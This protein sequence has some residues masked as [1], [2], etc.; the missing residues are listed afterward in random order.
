MDVDGMQIFYLRF[1]FNV[2]IFYF[3]ICNFECWTCTINRIVILSMQDFGAY[4]Q[5]F[6]HTAW[7]NIHVLKKYFGNKNNRIR[8]RIN[9]IN[10]MS[11]DSYIV[12]R[13]PGYSY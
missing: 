9:L 3:Q 7:K 8:I 4:N 13:T 12:K 11:N 5:I 2:N 10:P 1:G 6:V